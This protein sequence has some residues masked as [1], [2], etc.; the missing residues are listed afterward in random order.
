[1]LGSPETSFPELNFTKAIFDVLCKAFRLKLDI[2]NKK[3]KKLPDISLD[4]RNIKCIHFKERTGRHYKCTLHGRYH[5]EVLD[6]L[7]G[8]VFHFHQYDDD[9]IYL[10]MIKVHEEKELG[11]QLGEIRPGP[12]TDMLNL[13]YYMFHDELVETLY[14]V[15]CQFV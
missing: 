7:E 2:F 9:R 1:M 4:P 12:K 14:K 11:T 8:H 3:F 6:I 5:F 15:K 10:T 13:I